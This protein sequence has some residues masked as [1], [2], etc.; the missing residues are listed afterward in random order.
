MSDQQLKENPDQETV[1]QSRRRLLKAAAATAP[2]IATLPNGAAWATAS[3]AQCVTDSRE[4]PL[5]DGATSHGGD[6]FVRRGGYETWVKE[7]GKRRSIHVCGIIGD[8]PNTYYSYDP[9]HE[10]LPT[11]TDTGATI[12]R[13][14]QTN[15]RIEKEFLQ[16]F[17]ATTD[18][19]GVTNCDGTDG[20]PAVPPQCIFPYAQG[21]SGGQP[22][23]GTCLCSVN[24]GLMTDP[25][26]AVAGCL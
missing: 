25:Q 18:D 24:P 26:K 5:P 20:G 12:N 21:N 8:E 13:V 4:G 7:D 19:A 17:R 9:P 3:T 1:V 22:L 23:L 10:V 11:I 15:R 16:F 14:E 6:R 2:L